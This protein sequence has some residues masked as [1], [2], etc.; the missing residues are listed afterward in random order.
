MAILIEPNYPIKFEHMRVDAVRSQSREKQL[1]DG[2]AKALLIE[3]LLK[4]NASN[5]NS[6]PGGQIGPVKDTTAQ[7]ALIP[8]PSKAF[9]DYRTPCLRRLCKARNIPTTYKD[10]EKLLGN[11]LVKPLNAY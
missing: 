3:R 7:S 5:S 11:A 1:G 6:F 2:G 4:A 10:V 8:K 9:S